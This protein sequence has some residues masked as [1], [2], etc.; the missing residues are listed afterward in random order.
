M[1]QCIAIDNEPLALEQIAS[2]ISKIATLELIGKF[3]N[4]T[5]ALDFLQNNQV[6]LLFVDID[7]PDITGIDLV[8]SLSNPPKVIFITGYREYAIDGFEVDA[9]DYLV[10]PIAFSA[11]A[12]SV[13][14]T[15][16]RY[17][18]KNE[19]NT[20]INHNDQFLFIK[21][22]YKI[23]RID[24]MNICYIESLRDYVKIHMEGEKPIMAL[25]TL[26]TIMKHLSPDI[27]MRV[28]RSFIVNLHK[29]HTIERNRIVFENSIYVP[30]S[31]QYKDSFQGFLDHNFLK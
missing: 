27:F 6:D 3:T 19:E 18:S 22:E 26:K 1:I 7:M 2:Y 14:K 21:S 9:A 8:K 30:I 28:H 25:L 11:F 31:D 13:E 10:K 24:I 29:V 20:T 23:I 12:K 4:A 15:K 17:F 16:Q 5:K